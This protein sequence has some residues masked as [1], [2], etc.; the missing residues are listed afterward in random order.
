MLWLT[1]NMMLSR[2]IYEQIEYK[3]STNEDIVDI[4][5]QFFR[6]DVNMSFYLPPNVSRGQ[7]SFHNVD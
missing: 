4:H 5:F 6:K 2:S 7:S 3:Y 1:D